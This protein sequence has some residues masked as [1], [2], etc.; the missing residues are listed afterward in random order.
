LHK[1]FMN[2]AW[3]EIPHVYLNKRIVI[4]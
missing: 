1:E 3:V 4:T 2:D